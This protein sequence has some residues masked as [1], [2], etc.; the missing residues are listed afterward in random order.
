MVVGFLVFIAVAVIG[1]LALFSLPQINEP[2]LQ[3]VDDLATGTERK[4]QT[5]T[6]LLSGL[7]GEKPTVTVPTTEE[8]VSQALDELIEGS[9]DIVA[10]STDCPSIENSEN[11]LDTT[12]QECMELQ[13]NAF[14]TLKTAKTLVFDVHGTTVAV[15]NFLDPNVLN[16]WIIGFAAAGLTILLVYRL[17]RKIG[18]DGF[19][20]VLI[21]LT[22]IILF[23]FVF[24]KIQI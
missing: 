16:A 3:A 10:S 17:F 7:L 11:P 24:P 2:I 4:L 20:I 12:S 22:I 14:A 8:G 1:S 15:V 9:E 19:Y 23:G 18:K 6:N 13:K 5:P 21:L